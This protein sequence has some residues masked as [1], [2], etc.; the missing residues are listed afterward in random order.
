MIF[1]FKAVQKC[2]QTFKQKKNV[3][4]RFMNN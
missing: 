4:N 1:I 2:K 3:L